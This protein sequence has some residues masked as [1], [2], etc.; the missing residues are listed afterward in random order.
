V[1]SAIARGY[2]LVDT[3][4][5]FERDGR[6]KTPAVSVLVVMGDPTAN[7]EDCRP[8]GESEAH[9]SRLA[10]ARYP[11]DRAVSLHL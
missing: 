7:N 3:A 10:A 8:S 1:K 9:F 2:R 6:Q 5:L 4:A 11:N